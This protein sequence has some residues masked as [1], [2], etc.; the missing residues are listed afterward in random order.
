MRFSE[1]HDPD[2]LTARLGGGIF[3]ILL[4]ALLLALGALAAL[5]ALG[6]M[7]MEAEAPPWAGILVGVAL[8]VGALALLSYRWGFALD[9][10][11]GVLTHWRSVLGLRHERQTPLDQLEKVVLSREVRDADSAR[12][13]SFYPVRLEGKAKPVKLYTS[14]RI[15]E[16]RAAAEHA[17]KVFRLVLVD[18]TESD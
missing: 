9:R 2:V 17:A 6:V 15:R 14:T 18:L 13:Y 7:E 1:T 11:R 16:A 3:Q 4:S 10:R 5:A 12:T 8:A